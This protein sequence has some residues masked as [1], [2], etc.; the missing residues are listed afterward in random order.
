[1]HEL[2]ELAAITALNQ[3]M[4][5]GHFSI[6]TIDNVANMLGVN[7][8]GMEAYTILST[9]HCVDFGKMPPELREAIPQL[10]RQCLNRGPEFQFASLRKEVVE[11]NG[12]WIQRLIGSH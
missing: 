10:I 3:M 8:R 2:K 4:K 11:V 5:G 6:C 1:M 12:G 9:L 7:C